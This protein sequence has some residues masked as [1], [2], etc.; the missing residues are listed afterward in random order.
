MLVDKCTFKTPVAL[1]SSFIYPKSVIM[2]FAIL[3]CD[4]LLFHFLPSFLFSLFVSRIVLGRWFFPSLVG[5]L[6]TPLQF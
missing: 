6:C 4:L 5:Q 3:E 1:H 2:E